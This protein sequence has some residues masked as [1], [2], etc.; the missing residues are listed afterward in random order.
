MSLAPMPLP[1]PPPTRF[2]VLA[3][4][5][6]GTN[7]LLT[8]LGSHP[9]AIAFGE[10]FSS[11]QRLQWGI[12]LAEHC[13]R[14]LP[15]PDEAT[16]AARQV[17]P[18][19]FLRQYVFGEG[20]R[21]SRAVGFKIFYEHCR[22]GRDPEVWSW[23]EQEADVAVVHLK[24]RNILR[25]L[26]SKRLANASGVWHRDSTNAP[27]SPTPPP[28]IELTET[29]CREFFTRTLLKEREADYLFRHHRVL[30]VYYEDLE[31][32]PESVAAAVQSFLG[33]PLQ[34]LQSVLTKQAAGSLR[35]Q[36][37]NYDQLK[38]AFAA[39]H[40]RLFFEL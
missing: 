22:T 19:G 38:Q 5:R 30:T 11:S 14:S 39:D 6:T 13:R 20:T 26:L 23:L 31:A 4:Q 17:D 24:R 1:K 3:Q 35:D 18:V 21:N 28:T 29:D 16:L 10:I 27:E 34:P 32:Q 12:S 40:T 15:D 37:A 7:F 2:I 25:T 36:I 8:L 9:D 33:L